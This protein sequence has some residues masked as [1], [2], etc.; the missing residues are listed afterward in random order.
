MQLRAQCFVQGLNDRLGFELLTF[1]SMDLLQ[2]A[3][4][5]KLNNEL[6]MNLFQI[7]GIDWAL[8]SV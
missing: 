4:P 8:R 1:E 6:N 5:S 7:S 3:L 2:L